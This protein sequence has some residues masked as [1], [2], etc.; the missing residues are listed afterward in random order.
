MKGT[1]KGN[2]GRVIEDEHDF[3]VRD[4]S[5]EFAMQRTV[6]ATFDK[7]AKCIH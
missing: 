3:T 7:K 4:V 2:S 6:F 1:G 5:C